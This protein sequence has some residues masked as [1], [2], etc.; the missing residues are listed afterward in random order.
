MLEPADRR[1]YALLEAHDGAQGWDPVPRLRALAG[2]GR[3]YTAHVYP[4]GHE[5]GGELELWSAHLDAWLR[6]E[7]LTR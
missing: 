4:G 1:A 7:G 6:A 5:V 3:R 2:E